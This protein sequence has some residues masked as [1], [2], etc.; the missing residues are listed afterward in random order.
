MAGIYTGRILTG[1]KAADLPVVQ[2]SKFEFMIN[3]KI[4]G[5]L[6]LEVPLGLTAGADAVIK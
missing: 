3:L 6:G 1:E 4:A 5:E 2:P